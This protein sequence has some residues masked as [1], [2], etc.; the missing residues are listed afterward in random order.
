M[1]DHLVKMLIR[2]KVTAIRDQLDSLIDQAGRRDLTTREALA[3][4]CE[5]PG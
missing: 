4:F 2:L 1:T 5:P 3:L